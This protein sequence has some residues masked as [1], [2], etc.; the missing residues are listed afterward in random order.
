MTTFT[1]TAHP[2][3]GLTSEANGFRSRDAITIAESQ[4]IVPGAVLGKVTA[5]GQY[6]VYDPAATDGSE[7]AAAIAL[8]P[9]T[10]AAGET[11]VIAAIMRDAEFRLGSLVFEAAVDQ[12]G[13]D[14]AIASL[15]SAHILARA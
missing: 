2:M 6:V 15:A 14:A 9:A 10:T 7:T 1:E 12:A 13:Q 11:Q 4:T 8:Y 3:E 5:T